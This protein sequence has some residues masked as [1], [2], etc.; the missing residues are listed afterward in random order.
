[1]TMNASAPDTTSGSGMR[2][3]LARSA[4]TISGFRAVRSAI[5]PK[6]GSAM[7]RAAG[8]AATISPSV[9]RSIPCDVR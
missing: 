1:M 6:I 2:I 5:Q 7:R 3:A 4:A 8:Q 9:A